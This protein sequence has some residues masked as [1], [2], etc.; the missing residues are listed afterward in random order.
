MTIDQDAE[1]VMGEPDWAIRRAA[2]DRILAANERLTQNLDRWAA[3]HANL[4]ARIAE[5][6]EGLRR[7]AAL[8]SASFD[9][10]YRHIARSLLGNSDVPR[11]TD[12]ERAEAQRVREEIE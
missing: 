12:A 11:V 7:I 1:T 2:L 10:P 6:E 4:N 5:L 8:P 9:E 3:E